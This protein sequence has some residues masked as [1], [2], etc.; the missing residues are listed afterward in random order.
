MQLRVI[1]LNA[2]PELRATLVKALATQKK[3]TATRAK[4]SWF[5][6]EVWSARKRKLS[7]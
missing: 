1:D 5:W 6:R 3:A 7:N 2:H 4:M